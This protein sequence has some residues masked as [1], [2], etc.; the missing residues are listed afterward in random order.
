MNS[1]QMISSL[2][3]MTLAAAAGFGVLQMLWFL[4]RRSNRQ[5]AE[6]A[7]VGA[8]ERSDIGAL[9]EIA[10]I[11]AV[12]VV[13][14]A[15]LVFGYNARTGAQQTAGTPTAPATAASGLPGR[16]GRPRLPGNRP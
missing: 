15:L 3:F 14:M 2:M 8:G 12:A 5:A 13:A 16:A 10:G 7:L 4:Q 9:P 6:H 1:G 11:G